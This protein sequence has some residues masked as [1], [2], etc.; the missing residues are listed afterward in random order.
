MRLENCAQA[1]DGWSVLKYLL[2]IT[3]AI[4]LLFGCAGPSVN[5]HAASKVG[6]IEVAFALPTVGSPQMRAGSGIR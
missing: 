3:I 5:I 4:L 1:G 6:N 2:I